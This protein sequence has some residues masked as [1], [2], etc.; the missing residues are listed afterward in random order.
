M[1]CQVV[2]LGRDVMKRFAKRLLQFVLIIISVCL[3]LVVALHF[4]LMPPASPD[5]ALERADKMAWLNN[6]IEAEPLYNDAERLFTQR[7]EISKALYA[8]VSQMPARMESRSLPAQIWSLTQDLALPEAQDP[9]TRLRILLVKGMIE[10]NYDGATARSTW[11]MIE[12]L[13]RQQHQY[14]LATRA[15]GEQGIAAFLLGDIASARAHVRNA[16]VV[17]KYAGDYAAQIRYASVYG[18]GLVELRKYS[19]SFGPLDEAIRLSKE[20]PGMPY[21]S[22]AVTAKIEALSGTN[23]HSEA[24]TLTNEALQY[25][26]AHGLAGHLYQIL[27]T[28]ADVYERMNRWHD[29]ITD[30]SEALRRA[31]QISYWRG[32]TE[33]GGPLAKAYEREGDLKQALNTIN[34]AIQA[35]TRIP[36]ELYFAPRNMAI[37]AEITAKMGQTAASNALY[38]KSADLIDSLL[39]TAPTP[40]VERTLLEELSDVYSGYFISLCNQ[41][42]YRE[43]FRVIEKARGRIEAQSLQHHGVVQPHPPT[44]AELRLNALDVELLNTDDKQTRNHLSDA[45]YDVEQQLDMS[46]LEGQTATN[47][48]DLQLLQ[49]QLRP[50]ELLVEYVLAGSHSYALAITRKTVKEY[51]LSGKQQLESLS[52]QYRDVIDHRKTD[53]A[54]AQRLFNVLLAGIP[55][56][57]KYATVIIVPDGSLHLL[58]FSALMD[59]GQYLIASHTITTAPSGTVFALLRSR[60][61]EVANANLPYVGVAAW[62][63]TANATNFPVKEYPRVRAIAGPE[64]SLLSPLPQSQHEVESIAENLPKPSELLLGSNATET[65]FKHLPLGDYNVLHLALHGFVDLD[66]PDRSAL[67]FAPQTDE[68]D[69]GL[70]QIREI[71][72]LHLN[73]NLVTLSACNTGVGPVGE[74]GVDNLVNAFIQAGAQSVVSTLWETDDRSTTRLMT[75]FYARLAHEE[76]KSTSLRKAELD[77]INSGLPP[78]YW[79]PFELVGDPSGTLSEG[80]PATS[81]N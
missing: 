67:V 14:L 16:Y 32:I 80:A 57:T 74:E 58:P 71:R 50:S 38:Q 43:A 47:P 23:R 70:L 2:C 18:A 51:E 54:L 27:S 30:Y 65:H 33:V 34:E 13:A 69:D 36:D 6:W 24:L 11:Q 25:A 31:R 75:N 19:E 28:R 42:Q 79:A 37:K 62:T 1:C 72:H 4:V 76:A 66:Y 39:A 10:T 55:E 77:L 22:I 17:A 56:Y 59:Q 7:H 5:A 52:E 63:K 49:E 68:M 9:Q 64:R 45:I 60:N 41:R 78:Y 53:H 44:A 46:S 15:G 40:N 12:R 21:P 29:A 81:L 8:R 35:N 48:V 3:I 73:A 61:H 20:R 26:Q